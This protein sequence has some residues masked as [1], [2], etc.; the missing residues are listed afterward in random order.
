[1]KSKTRIS[2]AITLLGLTV[3]AFTVLV[4]GNRRFD[5][6]AVNLVS[7]EEI[8]QD[9]LQIYKASKHSVAPV[10]G[11]VPDK[12]TAIKIALAVWEN[13]YGKDAISRQA[14]FKAT[15]SEGVWFVTGSLPEHTVG[16]VA[17]AQI[18]KQDARIL[19]ISHS[20]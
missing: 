11:L 9:Q 14:P 2:L 4:V 15:L 12:Q 20:M 3:I 1:M 16:G 8:N 17:I 13:V 5:K 7:I 6:S 19:R 10:L 18:S